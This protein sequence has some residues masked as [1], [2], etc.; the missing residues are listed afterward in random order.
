M[1]VGIARPDDLLGDEEHDG[2][3]HRPP[4]G[5]L[6]AEEHH[7]DH[8]DRRRQREDADRL[9][10]PLIARGE[11]ARDAGPG[12]REEE[13]EELVPGGV[14]AHRLGGHLVLPD[15]HQA[16]TEP[17][18]D[19]D[20]RDQRHQQGTGPHDVID[21]DGRVQ[22]RQREPVA[23]A[24][25][26]LEVRHERAEDLVETEHRDRE[27]GPLEPEARVADDEREDAG[28]E[29]A[30]ERG[31]APRPAGLGDQD[32]TRV[33]AGAEERDVAERDVAGEPRDEVPG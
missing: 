16:Q 4:D 20:V 14:D 10:V 24:G 23:A 15:R 21:R 28:A 26:I 13:G 6:P 19:D 32:R 31:Q 1:D 12:R 7:H 8:R 3:E 11:R 17:R 29:P 18:R 25:Q 30:R 2:A 9:D 27:V 22:R 5:A 33:G